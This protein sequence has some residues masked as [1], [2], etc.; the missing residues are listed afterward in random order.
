MPGAK[1][2][3]IDPAEPPD[4]ERQERAGAAA[5]VGHRLARRIGDR[6]RAP[7]QSGFSTPGSEGVEEQLVVLRRV[8]APLAVLVLEAGHGPGPSRSGVACSETSDFLVPDTDRALTTMGRDAPGGRVGHEA[9]DV[10]RH[11]PRRAQHVATVAPG[12]AELGVGAEP[13]HHPGPLG[14]AERRGLRLRQVSPMV[15]NSP[16]TP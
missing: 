3:A 13:E 12:I 15:R 10:D 14:L 16:S 11:R 2:R 8:A 9:D 5:E 7:S 1:S 6:R 4:Q